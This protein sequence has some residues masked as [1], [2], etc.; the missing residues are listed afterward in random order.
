[1]KS[2]QCCGATI[3]VA[4]AVAGNTKW[5]TAIGYMLR[6]LLLFLRV[7]A[8][9]DMS[10]NCGNIARSEKCSKGEL[11]ATNGKR[12]L[13]KCSVSNATKRNVTQRRNVTAVSLTLRVI[14]NLCVIGAV[15]AYV[16]VKWRPREN[17]F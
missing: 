2:R 10:I 11:S 8:T 7:E 17:G 3:N 1:M 9:N 14:R 6:E 13:Q 4:A 15:A 12:D 16:L 5:G